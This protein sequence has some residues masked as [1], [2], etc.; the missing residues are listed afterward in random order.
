ME[1]TFVSENNAERK[2]LQ[3]LVKR[4]SD[5][6]LEALLPN[7]LTVAAT[8]AHLAFWDQRAY[9]LVERWKQS[10][11][12]LAPLDTD[13]TN[14]A[15]APLLMAIPRRLAAELALKAAETV[16]RAI[17]QAPDELIE[18]IQRVETRFRI[19][20]SIHRQTHLD[21]IEAVLKA[22]R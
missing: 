12:A 5:D 3:A 7:G 17:E 21:E 9:V 10:G 11:V 19:R 15:M 13:T 1:R 18:E 16:D 20:R 2:R 6:Q 4:L 22:G 8:L 14:D